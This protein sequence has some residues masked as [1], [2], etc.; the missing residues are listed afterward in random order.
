MQEP[1]S[2]PADGGAMHSVKLALGKQPLL[3]MGKAK[4]RGKGSF[5]FGRKGKGKAAS[6]KKPSV[7]RSGATR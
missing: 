5:A 7:S 2:P 6:A 1:A 3:G 4:G